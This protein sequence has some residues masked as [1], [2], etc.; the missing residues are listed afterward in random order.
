MLVLFILTWFR[1]QIDTTSAGGTGI[2]IDQNHRPHV[3]YYSA[4]NQLIHSFWNG[5][6]WQK[7]SVCPVASYHNGGPSVIIDNQ[8]RIHVAFFNN[9]ERLS[10]AVYQ[11]TWQFETVDTAYRT[12]DYCDI[13]LDSNNQPHIAYH[14]STGLF[15]GYL[16]YA[17]K[18]TQWQIYEH[19][20]EYGGY[21]ASLE[22]DSLDHPH[23]SDCNDWSAG[24]LRYIYH[25]GQNWH[26]EKPVIGN[27]SGYNSLVLDNQD[28]PQIS[29]YW[30]G[31]TSFDL[32]FTEKNSGNWQ[33][34]IVDPGQQPFKRGWEN[35]I[36]IDNNNNLHIAYHCHNEGLLKYAHGYG[37]SWSTEIV[38]TIGG[39][40]ANIG[41]AVDGNDIYISYH[42][43]YTTDVWVASTR[44][45]VAI[46]ETT[47]KVIDHR[48]CKIING[49]IVV[50]GPFRLYNITGCILLQGDFKPAKNIKL[51]KSGIYFLK[52]LNSNYKIVVIH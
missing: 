47:V 52:T 25:D 5:T 8:N 33:I 32:R 42:D 14:R 22:L 4:T 7:E 1:F 18:I 29:L 16:R 2:A 51:N 31:G 17:V 36:A 46:D 11:G 15:S 48:P 49:T 38:D 26:Y 24:D 9:T 34:H 3:L 35:K 37:A 19:S 12:G 41:I 50:E 39:Y 45:L 27:A 20:S 6:N 43:E 28:R 44:N 10:Y 40:E 30:V 21:H 13:T 23:I